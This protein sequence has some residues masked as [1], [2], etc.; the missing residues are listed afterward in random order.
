[1]PTPREITQ[2]LNAH[3][4]DFSQVQ[5]NSL[6]QVR[7][8]FAFGSRR[9]SNPMMRNE[10]VLHGGHMVV[11][12]NGAL[13]HSLQQAEA[14]SGWTGSR[15][16]RDWT[17]L[18]SSH[19]PNHNAAQTE[20]QMPFNNQNFGTILHGTTPQGH[21]WVQMEAHSGVTS[22]NGGRLRALTDY[23][24]HGSDYQQYRQHNQN[25]GP[26]GMS[27]FTEARPLTI[28]A[29]QLDMRRRIQAFEP[30]FAGRNQRV[31]ELARMRGRRGNLNQA[32]QSRL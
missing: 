8:L 30:I 4:N 11:Q 6:Q 18:P 21:S 31:D 16:P 23:A 27:R 15:R 13:N 2:S 7:S 10:D 5:W 17:S 14:N 20:L 19:Y 26:M 1:M 28:T 9:H 25:I 32:I 29:G 3:Q 24:L 22:V 12:D